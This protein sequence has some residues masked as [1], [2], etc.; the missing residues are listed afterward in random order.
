VSG[1]D[2]PVAVVF[3][4]D[5][6]L[7]DS[8]TLSR[9]VWTEVLAGHGV[10]PT[11]ADFRAI[12]GHAWPR[13]YDHFSRTAD[14]GD[15]DAF[16]A[17]VR[18]VAARV[19]ETDLE[20]FP[21]AVGTIVALTDADVPVAVASSSSRAH[22]LRCLDRGDLRDRVRVVIGADD[23]R[24]HKPHPDPYLDAAAGLGVAPAECTTVEDTVTG[25]TS[26]RA[27]GTFTVAVDRGEVDPD[28]LSVADRVV[29]TLSVAALVPPRGWRPAA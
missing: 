3:D 9:R 5:G 21:D 14:I 10:V 8:E 12:I 23:V 24:R 22:V 27:A 29:A 17:E 11:A 28:G 4:C 25:L 18:A 13:S 19:H 15:P 6:T 26:A 16:R 1:A 2:L 20:L 7:A